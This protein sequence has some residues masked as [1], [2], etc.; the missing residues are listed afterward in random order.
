[1]RP[2]GRSSE[3]EFRRAEIKGQA[4]GTE[5]EEKEGK[6]RETERERKVA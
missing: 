3:S 1:M 4:G 5:E 6:G 2:E